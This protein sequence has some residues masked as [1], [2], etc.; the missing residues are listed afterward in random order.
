MP[1]F[2]HAGLA[3]A[4]GLGALIN[5]AWLW[6]G[7]R[8]RQVLRHGAGWSGLLV[9]V[10]VAASAMGAWL[11]WGAQ[12]FAWHGDG[13]SWVGRLGALGLVCIVG[14]IIYLG[15]LALMGFPL[16]QLMQRRAVVSALDN[17]TEPKKES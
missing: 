1:Y 7:L 11:Y 9:R 3:L 13:V 15:A 2:A 17:I 12:A 14:G 6:I 10:T 8:R 5:A 16:R 4:I